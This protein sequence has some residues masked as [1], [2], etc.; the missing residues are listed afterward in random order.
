[1]KPTS[2]PPAIPKSASPASPGP[3]AARPVTATSNAW[4]YARRRSSTTRAR[5]ST[6]TLSR[7]QDGQAIITGP[8]PRRPSALRLPHPTSHSFTGASGG[9]GGAGFD[10]GASL[11]QAARLEDLPRDFDL[12]YGV[13]GEGDADRVADPVHEERAH[14]D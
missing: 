7:P 4:G 3:V 13:G 10:H 11:A 6:P 8:R 2:R 1:M 14:A 9:G 5:F 12:L